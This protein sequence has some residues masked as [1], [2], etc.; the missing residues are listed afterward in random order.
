MDAADL[1]GDDV[2]FISYAQNAEDV[3]LHRA[4]GHVEHGFYIDVG[5][6]DPITD[7]VTRAFYER[8]WHGINVEPVPRW[9]KRLN[10]DRPRDLNIQAIV[11]DHAG[12]ETIREVVG[13]GLS[14]VDA[15]IAR[16]H[17]TG[18]HA[19]EEFEVRATT[20]D[21]LCRDHNVE[22]IHFLKVDV[23]GH[24]AKVLAGMAF[25]AYRPW[26]LLIEATAPN[27]QVETH[28]SW[29]PALLERNYL[30]VYADGLNRFYVAQE[31]FD[32][33]GDFFRYPPNFFD[34]YERMSVN[35]LR[36]HAERLESDLALV[37]EER[38]DLLA[39]GPFLPSDLPDH[40]L[41]ITLRERYRR[42]R[43]ERILMRR[44]IKDAQAKVLELNNEHNELIELRRSAQRYRL[45]LFSAQESLA[46]AEQRVDTQR[47]EIDN[48]RH[49]VRALEVQSSNL[50][51]AHGQERAEAAHLRVQLD[52][53]LR[54]TSWR[55]TKP[56]RLGRRLWSNPSPGDRR[57]ALRGLSGLFLKTAARIP[58][59]RRV[60]GA[61]LRRMPR[62]RARLLH[63]HGLSPPGDPIAVDPAADG[64]SPIAR[65]YAVALKSADERRAVPPGDDQ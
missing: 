46:E 35:W 47:I 7:S 53:I 14:T 40:D 54:S 58:G 4:L 16:Q 22:T 23:E 30:F 34:D 55:I 8:G 44:Q 27:S 42:L 50:E 45:Q 56:I 6:Q 15:G 13:T 57:S 29:E 63:L 64:L 18:G 61:L 39:Q 12:I 24:E 10:E 28:E 51:T 25:D 65:M 3:V 36:Q 1:Q 32:E 20:L 11:A 26:V 2:T 43:A 17:S 9:L 48:L 19:I 21:D 31:K 60:G 41:L 49:Y 52:A 38:D 59:A 62:F 33:L 37:T 5:A